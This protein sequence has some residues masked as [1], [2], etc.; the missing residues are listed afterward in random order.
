VL[1]TS[2]FVLINLPKTGSSF[3][4][5]VIKRIYAR[6][7]WRWRADRYLKELMLPRD[8]GRR[9]GLSQHGWVSQVPQGYRHLPLVSVIR[10]PYDRILSI[11]E[12]RWWADHPTLPAAQ[13]AREFPRF[14]N[15]TLDDFIRMGDL[16]VAERL[17]GRN[18]LGL[19]RQTVQFVHFFF[20]DPERALRSLSDDYVESGAFRADMA[21]ITFLRQERLRDELAA[22]LER[23]A[24]A[25]SEVQ[26]C[27]RLPSINR[28]LGG[29]ADRHSLWTPHAVEAVAT[30]E[31]F[32]FRMLAQL[33]IDYE[34]PHLVEAGA[35][36]A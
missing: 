35:T 3:V 34:A 31:R 1:I 25:A 36:L 22:M 7:R 8:G 20:H 19:G 17:D 18:P 13:L 26:L 10:N 9:S 2:Q 11:Y 4:R 15:L 27:K 23:F 14:P 5:E 16:E 24:F 33:G 30:R 29:V 32:L 6:R 28:T 12:Y 21:P